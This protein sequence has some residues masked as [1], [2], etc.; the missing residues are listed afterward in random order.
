MTRINLLPW[1]EERR[2]RLQR[3]FVMLMAASVLIGAAAVL[4]THLYVG[5]EI[6][7]QQTRNQYLVSE[8]NRLKAAAEEMKKLDQAKARLL[9]RL[10]IIQN[11]QASRPLM[12]RVFDSLA[13]LTPDTVYLSSLKA[14][15]NEL[16]L[17]G[18]ALSNQVVSDF[19]RRLSANTLF[20]EPALKQIE[21]RDIA[22]VRVSTFEMSVPR[23]Q[24]PKDAAQ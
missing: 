5:G 10:E 7:D 16:V 22:G 15:G 4:G 23:R 21:N 9:A 3:D 19:M 14:G 18:T 13:R 11:L 20:A 8:I 6:E 24:Q 1:R 17:N 12:V 2:L